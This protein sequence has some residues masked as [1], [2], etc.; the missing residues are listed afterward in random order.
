VQQI[1]RA[2]NRRDRHS[3]LRPPLLGIAEKQGKPLT[4]NAFV[5]FD[6]LKRFRVL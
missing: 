2:A 6:R 3:L 5:P 1:E 4:K